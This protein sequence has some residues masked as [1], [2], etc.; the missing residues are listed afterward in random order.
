MTRHTSKF[1]NIASEIQ[2]PRWHVLKSNIQ[3]HEE[4]MLKD[5]LKDATFPEL[6]LSHRKVIFHNLEELKRFDFMW[7][8]TANSEEK[9]QIKK[10]FNL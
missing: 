7:D 8:R 6:A 9:Q 2:H 4:L 5:K 3:H 10:L 1:V